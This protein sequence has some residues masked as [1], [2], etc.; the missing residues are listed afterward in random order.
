[1]EWGKREKNGGEVFNIY[2]NKTP[3]ITYTNKNIYLR[4]RRDGP[5]L[6]FYFPSGLCS[7]PIG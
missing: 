1:V 7:F 5:V 6:L 3:F 4:E 2:H